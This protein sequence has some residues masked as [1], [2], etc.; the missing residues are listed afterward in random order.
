MP[1]PASGARTLLGLKIDRQIPGQQLGCPEPVVTAI[2]APDA[3]ATATGAAGNVTGTSV[4]YYMSTI[5][6]G[7]G[8][9]A[10]SVASTTLAPS[11]QIVAV[12]PAVSPTTGHPAVL[13]RVFYRKID[14]GAVLEIKRLWTNTI[15]PFNDNV[16]PGAEGTRT[17]RTGT[18][19]TSAEQTAANFGFQ[20]IRPDAGTDFSRDDTSDKSTEQTGQL[21]EPRGIPGLVKYAHPFN[22]DA[23]IG[24]LV[25]LLASMRG[26]PSADQNTGEPVVVYGFPSSDLP[27]DS[28][29]LS[30]LFYKGGSLH[31]QL[32]LGSKCS[33]IDL[34][35]GKKQAQLKAK[36][37]GQHDTEAG[38]GTAIAG[39]ATAFASALVVRG[40]RSDAN[41]Y[42]DSV[43]VKIVAAPAEA[44]GIG[45]F[46]IRATLAAAATAA[47][48]FGTAVTSRVYYDPATKRQCHPAAIGNAAATLQQSAWIELW[49]STTGLA[50]GFDEG[51]NRKPFEVYFPGDV[52]V[53]AADDV[54]EIPALQKIPGVYTAANPTGP[55]DD[56][57][58]TGQRPRFTFTS[59]MTP[60]HVIITKGTGSS[61]QTLLD[62]LSSS[63]KI[64]RPVDA[65]EGLGPEAANPIDVDVFGKFVLS[66]DIERR[67]VDRYFE[68]IA[69][70]DARLYAVIQ[71]KSSRIVVDPVSG[72]L[73]ADREEATFTY[74]QARVDKTASAFSGDKVTMEKV[75]L[76]P[77]Q[78]DDD[79]LEA[80]SI[81]A[82]TAHSWD[83]SRV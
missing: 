39:N 47:P 8:E 20:F 25:P 42:T 55:S 46:T 5:Y 53:L 64:T 43:F 3:P 6:A 83:F 76:T 73:S 70:S 50:L 75:T 48:S 31:P 49:E 12:T 30:G 10:A 78:P 81:V 74:A 68:R 17:P 16:A 33:E 35:L 24:T 40:G 34:A 27:S 28:I 36:L 45:S 59:R 32:F 66:F 19:G 11:S 23:R 44:S 7:L 41:A 79:T 58:Y 72:T 14:S 22:C 82:K 18:T 37:T 52:S 61:T 57:S 26:K 2:A 77:E 4:L 1:S 56:G 67:Y 13:G 38:F 9:T 60:A 71:L 62:A 51:E 15:T 80:V 65:V 69:K 21:G 54:F 63:L 29:S